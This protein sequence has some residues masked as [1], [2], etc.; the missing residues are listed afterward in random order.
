MAILQFP[1]LDH[2]SPEG[3]LAVGGDLEIPSLKLAYSQ[4]IFPWPSE[5]LPL[6]WFAP[7]KRGILD[8]KDF[9]IPHRTRRELKGRNYR[10]AIDGN[11]PA[12]IR[13]CALGKTRKSHGTW[14]TLEMEKAYLHFHQTG[15]AHSFECYNPQDK[16]I[17]GLYGVGMGGMFAAESMF[18]EESGASKA[19]LIFMVEYLRQRGASWVDI[20][21]LSP[22]LENFGAKE[23][24]RT[25]FL[26][27]LQKSLNQ[28]S[29]F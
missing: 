24:E 1:P 11:F 18:F 2:A 14:I 3:L 15:Y 4:G 9:K 10:F 23:I 8:F 25:E 17:G 26:E 29:L 19:A 16:L 20:Q 6:L 21:V 13:A 12:V 27:R 7:W 28:P 5:G 22:L